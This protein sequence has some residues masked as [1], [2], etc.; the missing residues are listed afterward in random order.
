MPRPK[1]EQPAYLFHVADNARVRLCGK[2]FYLGEYGSKESYARYHALRAEY[3]ANGKCCPRTS[4]RT[5]WTA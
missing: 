2:D 4:K 5:R 3:N 1:L